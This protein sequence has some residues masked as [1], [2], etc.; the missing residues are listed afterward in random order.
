M[1]YLISGSLMY[2]STGRDIGA[3]SSP[4]SGSYGKWEH[5]LD[6]TS[7][8][9]LSL[10]MWASTALYTFLQWLPNVFD[11]SKVKKFEDDSPTIYV[12]LMYAKNKNEEAMR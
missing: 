8:W 6:V 1:Q 9:W 2:R 11:P 3:D 5:F 12:F 7:L 4:R 10:Q